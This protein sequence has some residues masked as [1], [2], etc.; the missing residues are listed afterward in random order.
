MVY[1]YTGLHYL[2]EY[3]PVMIACQ[4]TCWEFVTVYAREKIKIVHKGM[5][6]IGRKDMEED[7]SN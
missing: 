2:F 3:S 4:D 1:V 6:Y 5:G 7:F